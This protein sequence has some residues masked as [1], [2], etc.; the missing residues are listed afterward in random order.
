MGIPPE[1]IYSSSSWPAPC[2]QARFR[3][4]CNIYPH[5]DIILIISL[6]EETISSSVRWYKKYGTSNKDSSRYNYRKSRS[7]QQHQNFLGFIPRNVQ[8]NPTRFSG[9]EF[10]LRKGN[11]ANPFRGGPEQLIFGI[12]NN[13]KNPELNDPQTPYPL[14]S[15][16]IAGVYI[17]VSPLS[18]ESWSINS[19]IVQL[20]EGSP[21]TPIA[22][23]RYDLP[24]GASIILQEDGAEKVYLRRPDPPQLEGIEVTQAIQTLDNAIPLVAGK[25]TVARVYLSCLSGTWHDCARHSPSSATGTLPV[26]VASIADTFLNASERRQPKCD[27]QGHKSQPE[28]R[29]ACRLACRGAAQPK[30]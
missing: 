6:I 24:Q 20:F 3:I 23:R 26:D 9:R 28:L 25:A 16:D 5:N 13:V 8:A 17:R 10:R 21:P 18:R 22:G 12:G 7:G 1:F 15:D 4:Y 11:D 29:A 19:A 2:P 27:A 14:E 30:P